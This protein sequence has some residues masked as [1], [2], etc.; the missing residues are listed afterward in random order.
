MTIEKDVEKQKLMKELIKSAKSQEYKITA[1]RV[2]TCQDSQKAASGIKRLINEK[3][4]KT[5][6]LT[7]SVYSILPGFGW[8]KSF[9][10]CC[11]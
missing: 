10:N 4:S 8:L 1:A 7:S 3:Y 11:A 5:E 2:M 9:S 6:I